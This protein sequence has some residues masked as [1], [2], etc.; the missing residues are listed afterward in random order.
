MKNNLHLSS[1]L[2]LI[3]VAGIFILLSLVIFNSV[4]VFGLND[5][6]SVKI[7]EAKIAF[8]PAIL[9]LIVIE[10]SCSECFDVSPFLVSIREGN[11]EIVSETSL[12]S[13]SLEAKELI[14]KY[15]ILKLP[16]IILKGEIDKTSLQN[17]KLVDDALV[18]D[19]IAPPYVDAYSLEVV[20]IV[21]VII[22]ED[23]SCTVCPDF[24]VTISNLKQS[25]IFIKEE[26][27][28]EYSTAEGSA[29]IAT[30]GISK[31]PALLLS[32]DISEYEGMA[33]G[34]QQSGLQLNEGYY[35][36]ESSAP[37]I[38]TETGNLRG[39]VSLIMLDDSSCEE[40]YD[41]GIHKQILSA[42][43][44]LKITEEETVDIGSSAGE[45]L[46]AKYNLEKIPT[47]IISGDLEA[48]PGFD[49]I[50]GNVGTIEEDGSYVFRQLELLGTIVYRNLITGE[51]VVQDGASQA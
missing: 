27:V 1:K 38:E 43:L 25:G 35:V 34:L 39:L 23:T 47:A 37:Y 50:W 11:V 16:T 32:E 29:L 33:Q 21:S 31:V 8:E 14:D 24:D 18:L 15:N 28:V 3:G 13:G 5:P 4:Y 44:G 10:S 36:L 41:V 48:Y 51:I 45:E 7:N 20:G 26:N 42:N 30:Y 46:I 9:D 12:N 6:L 49:Q 40:C 2:Y 19:D 22:L 17:F